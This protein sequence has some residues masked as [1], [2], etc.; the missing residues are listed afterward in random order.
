MYKYFYV[1]HI[2]VP[3]YGLI[4]LAAFVLCNGIAFLI[5]RREKE[6][7][8]LFLEVELVASVA[9]AVGAKLF[10]GAG[11]SW[12]GGVAG[13]LTAHYIMW[14]ATR[15]EIYIKLQGL[16]F[17][18]PVFLGFCKVGCFMAGC[19]HG[20]PYHGFGAVVFPEGVNALTGM[21]V[22]PV[23]I[24]ETVLAFI[25]AGL[26][27]RIKSRH[28]G[29][30]QPGWFLALY[31]AERFAVEFLRYHDANVLFSEAH[32]Y[33]VFSLLIG[34]KLILRGRYRRKKNE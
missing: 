34:F 33:S 18:L 3:S 17:L 10:S 1:G 22:F 16:T 6:D 2:K 4:I 32:I 21:P 11:Y 28:G 13:F 9:G 5:I 23:Q 25:V 24:L 27:L 15:E 14:L 7:P 8:G 19:C 29:K 30:N 20:I 26:L 31:G 12:Y